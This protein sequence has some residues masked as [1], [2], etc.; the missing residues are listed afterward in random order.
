MSIVS[1]PLS[2]ASGIRICFH[3]L[4]FSLSRDI[5][6]IGLV[7][8]PTTGYWQQSTDDPNRVLARLGYYNRSLRD[9]IVW[10]TA[11]NFIALKPFATL[12]DQSICI[13]S[14]DQEHYVP[15]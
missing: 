15:V 3:I 2:V 6:S 9:L 13:L 10:I 1:R 4:Y 14:L 11:F 12:L 5:K 8:Q 7:P